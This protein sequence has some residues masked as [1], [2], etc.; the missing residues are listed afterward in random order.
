MENLF[1]ADFDESKPWGYHIHQQATPSS[2][3]HPRSP[4]LGL[5]IRTLIYISRFKGSLVWLSDIEIEMGGQTLINSNKGFIIGR[6]RTK[7]GLDGPSL[8]LSYSF[9]SLLLLREFQLTFKF[10][11][12]QFNDNFLARDFSLLITKFLIA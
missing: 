9:Q 10:R 1:K 5:S 8:S 4:W 7:A 11:L 6:L 2:V 12:S 3:I